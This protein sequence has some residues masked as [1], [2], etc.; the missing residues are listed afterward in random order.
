MP[1]RIPECL[2][3]QDYEADQDYQAHCSCQ[4]QYQTQGGNKLNKAL[5]RKLDRKFDRL[6]KG[7]ISSG[8]LT[9]ASKSVYSFEGE[10]LS[11]D[12]NEYNS[13]TSLEQEKQE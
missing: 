12:S 1:S 13:D 6:F 11:E 4:P 5:L 8:R 2:D 3:F 10:V 7:K 9:N